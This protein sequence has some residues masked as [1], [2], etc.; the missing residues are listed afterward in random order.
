MPWSQTSP[1]DQRTKFIA[2]Y[3]QRSI[4]TAEL[5]ERYGIAR[6]TGYKWIDRYLRFG[7]AGLE[8]RSRRPHESPNQTDSEIVTALL[9]VRRRHPWWGA[10]KLLRIVQ[11]GV[12]TSHEAGDQRHN[13][14]DDE[15]CHGSNRLA[16]GCP[17][18]GRV[19]RHYDDGQDD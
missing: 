8:E 9:E 17:H 16:G 1:M 18:D 14:R 4:D 15:L 11:A 6:K 5:C 7:P 19:S 10:K 2:D 12:D 13:Y 3:L